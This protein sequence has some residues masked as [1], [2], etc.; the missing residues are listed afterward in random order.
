MI[1]II[2][3]GNSRVKVALLARDAQGAWRRMGE[4]LALPH[5]ALSA[6]LPAWLRARQA[7]IERAVGV[8]VAGPAC[9]R[10]ITD[11]IARAGVTQIDWHLPGTELLGLKNAYQFPERL[12]ADRWMA[13]VGVWRRTETDPRRP[14]QLINVGTATVID[15]ISPD[16]T[17]IG[18][19]IL[20]GWT[21]MRESLAKGTAQLPRKD[22][23][24]L[25]DFPVETHDGITTGIAA[26][27]AGAVLRQW[28][29]A[30]TRYGLDPQIHVAGG[31][32]P[33][34]VDEIERL[35]ALVGMQAPVTHVAYPALDGLE[36]C[37]REGVL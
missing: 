3:S 6:G 34:V 21:L 19:L 12:G 22:Q 17:F 18:G 23:G 26:A 20:P 30:R 25:S 9:A 2:D 5:A 37:V 14:R 1:L 10:R 4:P 33:A 7:R 24:E 8:N 27:Q 36:A 35:L 32:L 15:T 29:I 16:G 11:A 31:A 28:L 13:L